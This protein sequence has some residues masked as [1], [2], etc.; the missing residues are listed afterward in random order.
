M[1][2][3]L[4]QITASQFVTCGKHPGLTGE[5]GLS[6][7][8]FRGMIWSIAR[9]RDTT[10]RGCDQRGCGEKFWSLNAKLV[11]AEIKYKIDLQTAKTP[12]VSAT[13]GSLFL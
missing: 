4:T 8:R 1:G 2:D 3:S 11:L 13:G 7:V 9:I 10:D 6:M 12:A 5:H